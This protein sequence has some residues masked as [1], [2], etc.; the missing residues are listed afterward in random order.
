MMRDYF[1]KAP[2]INKD[3]ILVIFGRRENRQN[4]SV[5][6]DE[7]KKLSQQEVLEEKKKKGGAGVTRMERRRKI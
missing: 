7:Y 4:E 1:V 2:L 6:S 5:G 3:S